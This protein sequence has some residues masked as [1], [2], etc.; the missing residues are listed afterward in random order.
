MEEDEMKYRKLPVVIEAIQWKADKQSWDEIV[1]MG[2]P[3]K[4]GVMGSGSFY[5]ETLEGDHLA[6]K[7]D[8]IVKGVKGEFYPIK[9]DIFKL[10][11]EPC[12]IDD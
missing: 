8:W 11:Y 6:K 2:T 10:T 7:G 1:A 9:P 3:W 5:I 12:Y 4:P